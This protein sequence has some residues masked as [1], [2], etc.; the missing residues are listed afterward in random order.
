MKNLCEKGFNPQFQAKFTP[1]CKLESKLKFEK[2]YIEIS[3]YCGLKCGFCPSA[4]M[5]QRR[6]AMDLELFEKICYEIQSHTKRVCLHILGDPLG[7]K[8]FASYVEIL[9]KYHLAVELVTTGLFLQE[10]H[11]ELLTQK[12][13]VQVAFSLSAFLA[14][15]NLLKKRHLE[16]I[17]K[18]CA[19]NLSQNSPI[20]VNL[21]L[22][23]DD[24]FAHSVEFRALCG[25]VARFFGLDFAVFIE[26]LT[27][28]R[29]RLGAK[30]FVN[31][32]TSFEW[33]QSGRV[34]T[35]KLKAQKSNIKVFCYGAIKQFGILSNGN[36]VPC[37]IDY[38]GKVSFGNVREQGIREILQSKK[39]VDFALALKRGKAPCELC[40]KCGYRLIL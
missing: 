4:S 25:S 37:C 32:K 38:G 13:F 2:I 19:F 28:G 8:D 35:H 10:W 20:F 11:F 12:P 15:E 9:K 5:E 21:R 31:P 7:V 17:L 39:F 24:I 16:Q 40:E 14:N 22:H 27:K 33:E 36:V 30:V 1:Q 18:F 34:K 26:K 23:S 6:G 3:D 29:V